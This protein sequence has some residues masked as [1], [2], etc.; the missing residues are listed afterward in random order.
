MEFVY[1]VKSTLRDIYKIGFSID[2][3]KRIQA[4]RC[5]NPEISLVA[6]YPGAITDEKYLHRYFSEK[7]VSNE[8]FSLKKEDLFFIR[9]Y[10]Q[11]TPINEQIYS[12]EQLT[13]KM[14]NGNGGPN[15]KRV[16]LQQLK[17]SDVALS[18][19]EIQEF[20]SRGIMLKTGKAIKS[21]WLC[22]PDCIYSDIVKDTGYCLRTV[23]TVMP[24][25]KRLS[26]VKEGM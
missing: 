3:E 25:L 26:G 21:S 8:W 2:P 16:F 19:E 23:Q 5:A 15:Q 7:K 12:F 24:I 10:M 6:L 13:I 9:D 1:V 14:I 17:N 20:K 11:K 4:L 22:M 18:P